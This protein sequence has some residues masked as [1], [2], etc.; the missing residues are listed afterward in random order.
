MKLT[1]TSV[2]QVLL[3]LCLAVL[4]QYQLT[5]QTFPSPGFTLP[6][7]KTIVITY[8][9]DVNAN[10]C[11]TGTV[12]GIK[13]SNQSNVSGSNFSTVLTDD[14]DIVRTSNPTLTPFGA[15][16][17][18]ILTVMFLRASTKGHFTPEDHFGF[19]AA[20]WYWHFV[21]VVW[22]CLFLFVYIL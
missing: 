22:I 18:V 21:D 20:S 17:L 19:E 15:L 16:T 5:A 13:I 1:H 10:A 3:I 7:G 14:P 12:P 8:E 11:P 6:N 2:S 4:T 9:V